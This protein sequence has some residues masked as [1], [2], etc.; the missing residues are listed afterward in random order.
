MKFLKNIQGHLEDVYGAKT[1]L[2]VTDFVRSIKNFTNLGSLVVE[3]ESEGDLNIALLL[4]RDILSCWEAGQRVEQIR[5]ITVPIGEVS[6]FVYLGFN[7]NRGRNITQLEMELQSEIDRLLVAF[8]GTLPI[9]DATKSQMLK[10]VFDSAYSAGAGDRYEEARKIACSFLRTLS[11]TDPRA[12]TTRDFETLRRFF[13]SDLSEKI[14]L[15]QRTG[16]NP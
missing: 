4:D 13:H 5:S 10:E 2:D 7:H 12:W 16:R 9:N 6:H 15:S 14:F 8:H 11:G 1:G 3:T